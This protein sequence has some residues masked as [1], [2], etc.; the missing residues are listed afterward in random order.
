MENA[1]AK[2]QRWGRESSQLEAVKATEVSKERFGLADSLEA[3]QEV[4]ECVSNDFVT[5]VDVG[6]R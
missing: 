2:W 6:E 3:I 4:F 1:V 5:S